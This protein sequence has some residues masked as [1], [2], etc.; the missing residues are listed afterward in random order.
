MSC[1]YED[2]TQMKGHVSAGSYVRVLVLPD[3]FVR[4]DCG[5]LRQG[6]GRTRY[7]DHVLNRVHRHGKTKTLRETFMYPQRFV[8]LAFCR[9][10]QLHIYH[11][12]SVTIRDLFLARS[13][14]LCM[15]LHVL[16]PLSDMKC[17]FDTFQH[18]APILAG[19]L[20]AINCG[21]IALVVLYTIYVGDREAPVWIG[22]FSGSCLRHGSSFFTLMKFNPLLC[23][24]EVA[25]S[26]CP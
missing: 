9:M 18:G 15:W 2:I 17:K 19:E 21:V 6:S 20:D 7:S 25:A 12:H 3:T 14:P 11:R 8:P 22:P 4:F 23:G 16:I 24:V 1:V 13:P 5:T 10:F 26:A